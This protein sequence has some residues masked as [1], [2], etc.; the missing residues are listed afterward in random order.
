MPLKLDGVLPHL[1]RETQNNTWIPMKYKIQ[2]VESIR[3]LISPSSLLHLVVGYFEILSA[4]QN[5]VSLAMSVAIPAKPSKACRALLCP[6]RLA[7]GLG[8][9]ARPTAPSLDTAHAPAS[10]HEEGC[11]PM[12][13]WGSTVQRLLDL[14]IPSA[15]LRDVYLTLFSQRCPSGK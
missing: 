8:C 13:H 2:S 7:A 3:R 10:P 4:H 6:V 14:S 5:A 15:V 9:E 11:L 1:P 12:H